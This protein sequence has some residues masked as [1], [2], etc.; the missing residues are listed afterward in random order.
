MEIEVKIPISSQQFEWIV[1]SWEFGTTKVLDKKTFLVKEDKYYSKD[2]ERS[3]SSTKVRLRSEGEVAIFTKEDNGNVLI[4][5]NDFFGNTKKMFFQNVKSYLTVKE[6]N[7]HPDGTEINRE[8]E[9][10][11][12]S[13]EAF[14]AFMDIIGYKPY[15]SKRKESMAFRVNM[16]GLLLNLEVIYVNGVGPYLEIEAIVGDEDVQ[17]A[18]TAIFSFMKD[19]LFLDTMLI[20]PR[21]WETII[22]S[23]IPLKSV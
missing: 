13:P 16:N 3:D 2:G 20:D 18:R 22:E 14:L 21:S 9:D 5:A 4:F 11:M 12:S 1:S 10:N 8:V 23:G 6:K 7:L 19:K 17:D 15:F